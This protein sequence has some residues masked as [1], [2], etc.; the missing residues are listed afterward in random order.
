MKDLSIYK[1][2]FANGL[3]LMVVNLTNIKDVFSILLLIATIVYTIFKATNEYKKIKQ[4][5]TKSEE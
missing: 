5:K 2:W 3:T 1:A 4:N